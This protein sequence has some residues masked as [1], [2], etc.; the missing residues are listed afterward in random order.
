MWEEEFNRTYYHILI[1]FH[2]FLGFFLSEFNKMSHFSLLHVF[3]SVEQKQNPLL[4]KRESWQDPF[5]IHKPDIAL[6]VAHRLLATGLS[7]IVN[8]LGCLGFVLHN[9]AMWKPA[10][11]HYQAFANSLKRFVMRAN[12]VEKQQDE[13]AI[14]ACHSIYVKRILLQKILLQ[15]C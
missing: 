3:T 9:D 12:N 13:N 1:M 11:S 10:A 14:Q 2:R 6:G 8:F 5:C 4:V 15:P 7:L